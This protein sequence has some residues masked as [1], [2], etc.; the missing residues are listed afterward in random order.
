M[1]KS[2][3]MNECD[4]PE[5]NKT[6]AGTELTEKGTHHSSRLILNFFDINVDKHVHDHK[7]KTQYYELRV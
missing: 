6:E 7:Q 3:D 2:S 5:S 4:A 1:Q